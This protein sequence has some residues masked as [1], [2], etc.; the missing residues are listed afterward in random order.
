V[1][2]VHIRENTAGTI[3]FWAREAVASSDAEERD[4]THRVLVIENNDCVLIASPLAP[5]GTSTGGEHSLTNAQLVNFPGN[6]GDVVIRNNR[7]NW[8][9]I[10]V[11]FEIFGSEPY[12]SIT[13][14]IINNQLR[15][16]DAAYLDTFSAN[17][18]T[19]TD[20][21]LAERIA[22]A[23]RV[24]TNNHASVST[25]PFEAFA[26]VSGNDT[27][28]GFFDDATWSYYRGVECFSFSKIQN[29]HITGLRETGVTN[30]TYG[31]YINRVVSDSDGLTVPNKGK[32]IISGNIIE[33][34][35]EDIVRYIRLTN[36]STDQGLI[37]DNVF[38]YPTVDIASTAVIA[39]A[40][41]TITNLTIYRNINETREVFLKDF[42]HAA[43]GLVSNLIL[44]GAVTASSNISISDDSL[45]GGNHSIF[46]N[47]ATADAGTDVFFKY[48][49]PLDQ[50]LPNGV[51]I[52]EVSVQ[53][54]SSALFDTQGDLVLELGEDSNAATSS[55]SADLASVTGT[56]TLTI[57]PSSPLGLTHG[58]REDELSLGGAPTI[59]ILLTADAATSK[60]V[61]IN[62]I[63]VLYRW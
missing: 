55:D 36:G 18:G 43:V 59:R 11:T 48:D 52:V 8:I 39:S 58:I 40:S 33:R 29:N 24:R 13:A 14:D 34:K 32:H 35:D 53:Y 42:G 21:I 45:G 20:S 3:G 26:N 61:Q 46:F 10:A 4:G 62:L 28:F 2:N 37:V 5:A 60:S 30:Q 47:Y 23:I 1:H 31:I 12:H 17:F 27:G 56:D 6:T 22:A 57:T 49:I 50:A 44:T 54:T 41:S 9:N 16:G 38:D 51:S 63:R 25:I 7:A 15:A 19:I